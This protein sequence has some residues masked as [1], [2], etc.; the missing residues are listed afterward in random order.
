MLGGT[1][2]LL[3]ASSSAYQQGVVHFIAEINRVDRVVNQPIHVMIK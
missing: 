2:I 3:V 1:F